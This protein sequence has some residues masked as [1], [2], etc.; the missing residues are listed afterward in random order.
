VK[1]TPLQVASLRKAASRLLSKIESSKPLPPSDVAYLKYWFHPHAMEQLARIRGAIETV[2]KPEH[3]SFF[4]V[5]L[6]VCVRKVS[7]ADPR[8]SVPVRLR[9]GQYPPGHP[10]RERTN[11]FIREFRVVNAFKVFAEAVKANMS[12]MA[13]IEYLLKTD[14]RVTVTDTDA[15]EIRSVPYESVDLV[16]TSP[17]YMGA[18][19][20]IRSSSLSLGW[21]GLAS[22]ME[23]KELDRQ[24]LGREHFTKAEYAQEVIT[25]ISDADEAIH[26]IY[27]RNPLRGCLVATYLREMRQI[28]SS[29]VEKIKPGGNIALVCS[30]NTV[31]GEAFQT[32]RYL[33]Q[34]LRDLSLVERLRLV[35]TIRSRGLMTK[36]NRTASMITREWILLYQK[37]QVNGTQR[38]EQR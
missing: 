33:A 8:V 20:Y 24:C 7:L 13:G 29:V 6:S 36:R 32:Q 25:G 38:H 14:S 17:P 5:C 26:R 27:A 12:R 21:L 30:N 23:L 9:A 2:R 31:C 10:L 15:R 35:D 34:I 28:L 4:K 18:Q 16:V 1:T 22:A 37:P 11:R 3:K 19:K